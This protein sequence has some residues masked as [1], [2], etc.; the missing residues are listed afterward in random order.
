MPSPYRLSPAARTKALDALHGVAWADGRLSPEEVSA[1]HGAA[2]VLG[3]D[4]LPIYAW[5]YGPP[6][7]L[8]V[9]SLSSRERCF[10]FAGGAWVAL[11]DGRRARE[12]V[13]L[14]RDIGRRAGLDDDTVVELFDVARWVRAVRGG[15]DSWANEFGWLLRTTE[16][17]LGPDPGAADAPARPGARG[18]DPAHR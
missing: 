15:S 4:P 3:A 12:E 1:A 14:L 18:L 2:L 6:P 9:D 5:R 7:P 13:E 10:V 11:V 17:A 16:D 8:V